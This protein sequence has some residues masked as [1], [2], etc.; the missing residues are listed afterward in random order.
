M[1]QRT[2]PASL[3]RRDFLALGAATAGVAG[4]AA[5]GLTGLTAPAVAVAADG[6]KTFTY[7]IAGDPG[8]NVNPVTT[9]DR[10]GLMTLK[11]LY[12]PL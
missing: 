12:K 11:L 8:S 6:S 9:S 4:L 2:A 1:S 3:S 5:L 10:F 7:A